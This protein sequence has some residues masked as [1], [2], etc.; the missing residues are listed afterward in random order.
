MRHEEWGVSLRCEVVQTLNQNFLSECHGTITKNAV[1]IVVGTDWAWLMVRLPL[2]FRT[3]NSNMMN[4]QVANSFS[5]SRFHLSCCDNIT[6]WMDKNMRWMPEV[7][8]YQ[9]CLLSL[10]GHIIDP[11]DG[12]NGNLLCVEFL[13]VD[14]VLHSAWLADARWD[15]TVSSDFRNGTSTNDWEFQ[16]MSACVLMARYRYHRRLEEFVDSRRACHCESRNRDRC[17]FMIHEEWLTADPIACRTTL[18]CKM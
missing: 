11:N 10:T 5:P 17:K 13:P 7:I 4:H 2:R 18:L 9:G 12:S 6:S 16:M 1:P 14:C 8:S 3:F 15:A